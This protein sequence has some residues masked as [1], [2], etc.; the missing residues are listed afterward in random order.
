MNPNDP[1]A[2]TITDLAH[3]IQNQLGLITGYAGILKMNPHLSSDDLQSLARISEAALAAGQ[4]VRELTELSM[5]LS[6]GQ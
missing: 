4:A 6:R 2:A 5:R 3:M 1:A